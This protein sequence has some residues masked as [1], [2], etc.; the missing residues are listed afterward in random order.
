MCP[1]KFLIYHDLNWNGRNGNTTELIPPTRSR[2]C[3][4]CEPQNDKSSLNYNHYLMK[5]F[6]P[7][8][9]P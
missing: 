6:S 2:I 7:F 9:I 5:F 3:A 8:G 4:L 1:I